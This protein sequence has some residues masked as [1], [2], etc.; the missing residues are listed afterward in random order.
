[1]SVYKYL[2]EIYEQNNKD[3]LLFNRILDHIISK[4]CKHYTLSIDNVNVRILLTGCIIRNRDNKKYNSLAEF[5]NDN[6]NNSIDDTDISILNKIK[7]NTS[8][9]IMN[10]LTTIPQFMNDFNNGFVNEETEDL[11]KKTQINTSYK[12][13][14]LINKATEEDILNFIDQ[15]YRTLLIYRDIRNF[16]ESTQI[17]KIE[18]KYFTLLWNN[19]LYTIGRSKIVLSNNEEDLYSINKFLTEYE[20]KIIDNLYVYIN[21]KKISINIK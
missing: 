11:L 12:I 20:D 9:N 21:N 18:K 15:K 8:Y 7:M 16:V 13:I 14:D 1:M 6:T 4:N 5:Y 10:M 2:K 19:E 3:S 17:N